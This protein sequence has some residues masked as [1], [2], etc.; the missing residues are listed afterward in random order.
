M[1]FRSKSTERHFVV[2]VMDVKKAGE[3]A[4]EEC[5]T[6]LGV[7]LHPLAEAK[8]KMTVGLHRMAVAEVA[9]LFR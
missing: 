2:A 3:A 9:E 6:I 5:E 4:P 1:L 8:E 7:Q